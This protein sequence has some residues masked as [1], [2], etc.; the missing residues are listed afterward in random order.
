[1]SRLSVLVLGG[2]GVISSAC[3]REA[4]VCGFEVTVLNRHRTRGRV[5][6][7]GVQSVEAD[8]RDTPAVQSALTDQTFDV[9]ANFLVWTEA[10]ARR[11]VELFG[12]R[13]QQYVFISS[14]SAYQ[15]PPGRLPI[16]ESTPLRNPFWEYSREKIACEDVFVRA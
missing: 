12:G 7:E 1:M 4:V 9:V 5:L 15:K 6:P 11:D 13:A 2:T 8:V 16:T 14:A 10:Q 3:V